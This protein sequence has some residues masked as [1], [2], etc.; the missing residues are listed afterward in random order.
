MIAEGIGVM[1]QTLRRTVTINNPSGLHMRPA[2]AFAALAS[3]FESAVTVA[4]AGAPVD[5]KDLLQLM[6]LAADC[7]TE[8]E[9]KVSGPDAATAL[10]TLAELL[11]SVPVEVDD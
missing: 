1:G 7:G 11:A 5:G 10:D 8:L 3:R 9:L 2:A 6:L 4:R